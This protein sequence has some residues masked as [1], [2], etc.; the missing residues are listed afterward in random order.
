LKNTRKRL[1]NGTLK[2]NLVDGFEFV[3]PLEF[4]PFYFNFTNPYIL[5]FNTKLTR[6]DYT[7]TSQSTFELFI[8]PSTPILTI[9][10]GNRMLG[11][12]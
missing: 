5:V 6:S 2:D 11:F 10:G 1:V 8:V 7:T 4:P 3:V 9:A 12:T